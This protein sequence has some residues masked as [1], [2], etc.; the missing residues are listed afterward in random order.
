M[1][2]HPPQRN[3]NN[4]YNQTKR[5][6]NN[7]S[8][9]HLSDHCHEQ[10]SPPPP[11]PSPRHELNRPPPVHGECFVSYDG[12]AASPTPCC[13][14]PLRN[15]CLRQ[16]LVGRHITCPHFRERLHNDEIITNQE[17]SDVLLADPEFQRRIRAV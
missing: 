14:K 11:P 13:G 15:N 9:Y 10:Q 1:K 4:N 6:N 16:W 7:I 5:N 2:R 8:T 3:Q 17:A 12:E